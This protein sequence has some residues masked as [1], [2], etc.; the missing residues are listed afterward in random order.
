MNTLH[1]TIP[2]PCHENWQL[3]TPAEKGKFCSACQKKV[4]DFT[5]A[6]DRE[7]I[8]TYS[9]DQ[10]LC[11]RFLNTQ[12]NREL[13]IPKEKKSIW[14]AS[15]FFGMI[16]LVNTKTIAQEKPKTEQTEP[17]HFLGMPAQIQETP[18]SEMKI[19]TGV[20]SDA[21]GPMPGVAVM[22]KGTTTGTITG[23]QGEYSLKANEG[24][25]L[26]FSFLGM[27][28]ASRIIENSNT[29]NV[30]LKDNTQNISAG[31]VVCTFKKRTFLARKIQKIR[32]WFK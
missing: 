12:L 3:M 10:K 1:I 28:E 16:A 9:A 21:A 2:K 31:I 22:I 6:T 29:I 23:I 19:I 30:I 27:D 8:Q 18:E 11:G 32:N 17:N 13:T 24:E 4:F 7:I 20:V 26:V 25:I 5:K 15:L 14:L